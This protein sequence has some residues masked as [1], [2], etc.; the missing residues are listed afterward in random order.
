MADVD[1]YQVLGVKRDATPE[2][3]RKAYKKI[4]RENHPDMKPNDKEAA[5][6]FKQAQE[7]YSVLGD[8]EKRKQY[9]QFG[10]AFR[11]GQYRGGGPFPGGGRT[12]TWTTGTGGAVDLDELFGGAGGFDWRDL[13]GMG[14]GRGA[15]Q[16][17]PARGQDLRVEIQVPFQVAALGGKHD[18]FYSRGGRP[19]TVTATIPRG[20]DDGS[21]IR[22]AGQGEEGPGGAGDLLVTVRVAPHPYF[23]REKNNVLIDVP[24]TPGEAALGAK[25]EVPTLD[26]GLVV[27]TV[28]EGSSS[29]RKLRL[30]GKGIPD[31]KTGQRGDQFVIL[32]IVV[33]PHPNDETREL[34]RKLA[35]AQPFDP[36]AGLW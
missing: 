22:L 21:V 31:R 20:I 23:R 13:F 16:A 2:E 7:A 8:P 33:P 17:P 5:E 32:K 1:Y 24:I 36:R 4:V 9:D 11:G 29:G 19:Q 30:R 10:H 15:R 12:Y 28:P 35:A 14:G 18:V 27:V 26:E 25:I 34:Y 3:I 6:R